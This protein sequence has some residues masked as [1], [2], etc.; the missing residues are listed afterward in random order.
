MSDKFNPNNLDDV[1]RVFEAWN[2]GYNFLVEF[3]DSLSRRSM[4]DYFSEADHKTANDILALLQQV[5]VLYMKRYKE[6]M[7]KR[8]QL[9]EKRLQEA[10][11][12]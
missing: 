7:D 5:E 6:V 1:N 2:K 12:V 4:S 9:M 11:N 10:H 3:I 8:V